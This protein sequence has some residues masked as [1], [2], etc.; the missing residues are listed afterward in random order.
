MY[1]RAKTRVRT[2][3]GDGRIDVTYLAKVR[4]LN[5]ELV[6]SWRLGLEPK[7]FKLNRTKN[8]YLECKFSDITPNVGIKLTMRSHC[9]GAR[10][11]KWRLTCGV[12]FDKKVPPKLRGKFYNGI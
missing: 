7:G 8:E 6:L 12:L 3:G 11:M 2:V 1:D 9:I 5:A 10:W 4:C